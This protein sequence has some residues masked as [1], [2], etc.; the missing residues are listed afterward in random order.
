MQTQHPFEEFYLG[1]PIFWSQ[2]RH[3]DLG[4]SVGSRRHAASETHLGPL[5]PPGAGQA[6]LAVMHPDHHDLEWH[7]CRGGWAG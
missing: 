6:E 4:S 1:R 3:G 5:S 2:E 7:Y